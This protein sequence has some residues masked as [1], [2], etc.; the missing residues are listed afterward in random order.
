MDNKGRYLE[1]LQ[2]K[3]NTIMKGSDLMVDGNVVVVYH[4]TDA[5]FNV[6]KPSSVGWFGGGVYF[7][8]HK[9]YDYHKYVLPCYLNAKNLATMDDLEDVLEKI[10]KPNA[11]IN[12][13]KF[14]KYRKMLESRGYDGFIHEVHGTTIAYWGNVAN[15]KLFEP[16]YDDDENLIPISMRLDFTNK[17]IRY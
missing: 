10:E 12:I 5:K 6:F 14:E 2:R 17:D 9:G 16:T 1:L 4:S 8:V 13:E 15:I 7:S 3:A 11:N